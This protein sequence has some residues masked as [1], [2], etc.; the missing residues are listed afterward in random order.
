M[1]ARQTSKSMSI[2]LVCRSQDH[3]TGL[4]YLLRPAPPQ[5]PPNSSHARAG[6]ILGCLPAGEA[7]HSQ[8]HG[9]HVWSRPKRQQQ[10]SNCAHRC[11]EDVIESR[12]NNPAC[13]GVI[14]YIECSVWLPSFESSTDIRRVFVPSRYSRAFAR[15]SRGLACSLFRSPRLTLSSGFMSPCLP[16]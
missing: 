14:L 7:A 4:R 9:I 15:L 12:K 5:C 2:I 11:G 10:S 1:V 3:L 6:Q 8:T 16:F 13:T